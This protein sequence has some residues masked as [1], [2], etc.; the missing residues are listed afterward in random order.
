MNI[1]G[2]IVLVTGASSGIEAATAKIMAQKGGRVLLL[3][4]TQAALEQVAAD[5]RAHGGEAHSFERVR[6]GDTC[7]HSTDTG[8]N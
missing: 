5:I 7:E 1:K 2:R 8:T 4:R 3:A 6:K